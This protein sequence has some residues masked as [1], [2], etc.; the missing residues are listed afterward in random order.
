[1]PR[2]SLPDRRRAVTFDVEHEGPEPTALTSERGARASPNQ[3]RSSPGWH[4]AAAPLTSLGFRHRAQLDREAE[5]EFLDV[6]DRAREAGT[7][8]AGV[9]SLPRSPHGP[10]TTTR[11]A[12]ASSR[13][14]SHRGVSAS[15]TS[16]AGPTTAARRS[17]LRRER[18]SSVSRPRRGRRGGGHRSGSGRRRVRNNPAKH[19]SAL[20]LDSCKR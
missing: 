9:A 11:P 7:G 1:M 3:V 2:E 4:S 6:L 16:Q 12:S 8:V 15:I 18:G 17:V 10:Q 14:T 19:E 13:A 20:Q 5:V